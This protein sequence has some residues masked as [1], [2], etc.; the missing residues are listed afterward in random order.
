LG[1]RPREGTPEG[2]KLRSK[3][4]PLTRRVLSALDVFEMFDAFDAFDAFE[5][6]T[7]QK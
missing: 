7:I 3:Q 6:F 2:C 5:A 4:I 1:S